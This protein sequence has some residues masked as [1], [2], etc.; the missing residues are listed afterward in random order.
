M[1]TYRASQTWVEAPFADDIASR[2]RLWLDLVTDSPQEGSDL[3]GD[4]RRGDGGLLAVCNK[5]SVPCTQPHLRLPGNGPYR[6]GQALE[7]ILQVDVSRGQI[8][9][10]AN[11]PHAIG[12]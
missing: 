1:G 4:R 11:Q 7:P 3:T 5:P 9:S 10:I 8:I 2:R 6:Q 12:D